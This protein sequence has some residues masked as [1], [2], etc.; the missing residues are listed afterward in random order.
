MQHEMCVVT[1]DSRT[2][3]YGSYEG[4]LFVGTGTYTVQFML[5]HD[6]VIYSVRELG[7]EIFLSYHCG[8]VGIVSLTERGYID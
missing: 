7:K 5:T 3:D 8:K 4:D 2:Q 6:A 1:S